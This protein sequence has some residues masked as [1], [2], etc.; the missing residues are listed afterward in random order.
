MLQENCAKAEQEPEEY[1]EITEANEENYEVEAIDESLE[2]TPSPN[3]ISQPTEEET[4]AFDIQSFD[5]VVHGIEDASSI[6][7]PYQCVSC[8][9]SYQ[10]NNSLM[11]HI[12]ITHEKIRH[13]CSHCPMEFTQKSSLLEHIRCIHKDI[14]KLAT[15]YC[16]ACNNKPFFSKKTLRQH[17][18][19]HS[20]DVPKVSFSFQSKPKKTPKRHGPANRR[21][22]P[23]CGNFFKNIEEHK[24]THQSEF[25]I[26]TAV[27][28][29]LLI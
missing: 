5:E 4:K 2:S 14:A 12:R 10:H 22:C 19:V 20:S 29:L 1:E 25:K 28:Q 21:Q 9:K 3:D 8:L 6:P 7:K 13:Q 16:E 27:N 17:M 18:K 26:Q 11:R 24:L 23:V 15:F